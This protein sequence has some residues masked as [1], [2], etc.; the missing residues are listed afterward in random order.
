[1]NF[2]VAR[3]VIRAYIISKGKGTFNVEVRADP[4]NEGGAGPFDKAVTCDPCSYEDARNAC[5]KLVAELAHTIKDHG[6]I[7]A[8][9]VIVDDDIGG[10]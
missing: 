3:Y 7:V 9:V 5:Y 6:A 4:L 8:D 10:R 1:M 2:Q